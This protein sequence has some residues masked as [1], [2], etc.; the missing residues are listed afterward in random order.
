MRTLTGVLTG[1]LLGAAGF[2]FCWQPPGSLV[3]YPAVFIV[4]L[5]SAGPGAAFLSL[6][7]AGIMKSFARTAMT[8]A[9]IRWSGV[10]FGLPLGPLNLLP[11]LFIWNL[12]VGGN[13]HLGFNDLP[14]AYLVGGLCGGAGLGYG[15]TYTLKPGEKC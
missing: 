8:R 13:T 7:L 11:S 12:W 5:V 14:V 2:C 15:V 6:V 10:L 1:I 4:M 9:S 3:F